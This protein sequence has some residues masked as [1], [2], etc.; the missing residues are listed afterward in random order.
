MRVSVRYPAS[1]SC[2]ETFHIETR[3]DHR[4]HDAYVLVQNCLPEGLVCMDLHSYR[5]GQFERLVHGSTILH[6]YISDGVDELFVTAYSLR[7]GT[8]WKAMRTR[9]ALLVDTL[10]PILI[11]TEYAI[12]QAKDVCRAQK[13]RNEGVADRLRKELI[14]EE[15]RVREARWALKRKQA[16]R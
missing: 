2:V 8:T 13:K 1:A 5:S 3:T 10:P 7:H 11:P 16:E 15:Q 14:Q 12:A 9:A 6:S 4:V